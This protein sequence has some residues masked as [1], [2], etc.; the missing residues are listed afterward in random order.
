LTVENHDEEMTFREDAVKNVF[1]QGQKPFNVQSP[2]NVTLYTLSFIAFLSALVFS[3][4]V[5]KIPDH[6]SAVGEIMTGKN[7][8]Q[9]TISDEDKI[10]DDIA[11]NE[12]QSVNN[13][14]VLFTLKDRNENSQRRN[15]ADLNQQ[16]ALLTTQ[17]Q[18]DKEFKAKSAEKI[19]LQKRDQQNT[20][21]Q[22]KQRLV[23]ETNILRRYETSVNNGL[24]AAT[25][26]DEQQRIVASIE[27]QIIRE[28]AV[29][30]QLEMEALSL[31]ER[32]TQQ[33]ATNQNE[34]RRLR[35]EKQ[36]FESGLT[37]TSPCDCVVD[38]IFIDEDLPIIA[39]QSIATLSTQ[40]EHSSLL[41]YIPASEYRQLQ[42]GNQIQIKVSAYPANKYGMLKAKIESISASPVPGNMINKQGLGLDATTYFVITAVI[43]EI[44]E[45]M[46]L[47]T[48]MKVNSDIRIGAT[49]LFRL[50]F[51]INHKR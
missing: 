15:I 42:L 46:S 2:P 29:F 5:I 28:D 44:P 30:T 43:N 35:F 33:Y 25:R 6:I 3:L 48:G 27:T 24:I 45:N 23:A 49:S 39:G 34:L 47:V 16:I 7:Y 18:R 41:L 36:S 31:E 37:I 22:L 12:A 1:S 19:E 8:Y 14:T 10:V 11:I 38:N 17:M 32:F 26:V 13:G 21:S 4:F 51:D 9:I 40:I 50:L 20:Q